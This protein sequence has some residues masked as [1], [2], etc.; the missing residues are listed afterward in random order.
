M[1]LKRVHRETLIRLSGSVMLRKLV[2]T[3]AQRFSNE[4]PRI[5]KSK[6]ETRKG[7]LSVKYVRNKCELMKMNSIRRKYR[8]LVSIS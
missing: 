8:K 5:K 2:V 4:G 1:F 3:L 7:S 6:D